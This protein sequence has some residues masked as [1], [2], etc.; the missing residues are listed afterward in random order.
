[1]QNVNILNVSYKE[2]LK[3]ASKDDL[4]YFDPPY[5]PLTQT[6]SFTSYSEFEFLEKEQIEKELLINELDHKKQDLVQMALFI[7]QQNDFLEN[8]QK[9]ISSSKASNKSTMILEKELEQKL[10]LDK[11]REQFKLNINLINEDFYNL[12]QI[13]F[14]NL[15]DGEKKLCAM[16]RLNLSSKEIASIQNI[17]PKSVDM[18]RYRLRKKLNL[19]AETELSEF[20]AQI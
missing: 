13:K 1:M 8:L 6:A 7:S 11:Q 17:S 5:F 2:V 10:N 3:Y 15:T 14:P 9:N 20:L 12:L 16:L 19:P 4:I 18:S